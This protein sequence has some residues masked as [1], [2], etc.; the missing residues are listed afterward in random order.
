MQTM[1][2]GSFRI[3]MIVAFQP[4][5]TG[6]RAHAADLDLALLHLYRGGRKSYRRC[7]AWD[8]E[9]GVLQIVHTRPNRRMI[10]PAIEC[11]PTFPSSLPEVL[12]HRNRRRLDHALGVAFHFG[13]GQ[14]RGVDSET[15]VAAVEGELAANFGRLPIVQLNVDGIE[16]N[17]VRSELHPRGVETCDCRLRKL[18]RRGIERQ[19]AP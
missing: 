5:R 14:L 7:E 12:K 13:D 10:V 17:F 16:L 8:V 11:D 15:G 1:R 9:D 2:Y 3:V 19:F 4:K 6:A 18:H